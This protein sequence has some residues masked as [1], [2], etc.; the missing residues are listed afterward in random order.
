VQGVVFFARRIP[1]QE[2]LIRISLTNPRGKRSGAILR[3]VTTL[4]APCASSPS[5]VWAKTGSPGPGV[6]VLARFE[7]A[8]A[9]ET[10]RVAPRNGS[11]RT[12]G[13]S[14]A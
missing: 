12:G 1:W 6:D 13:I 2:I 9:I 5:I 10:R 3:S 8:R 7:K 14:F 11:E 4:D